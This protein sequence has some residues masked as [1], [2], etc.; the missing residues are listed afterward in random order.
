M[1]LFGDWHA[2][3]NYYRSAWQQLRDDDALRQDT[4]GAPVL[5]NPPPSISLP[6][7][8]VAPAPAAITVAYD[9]DLRGHVDNA[10]VPEDSP[11]ES[12]ATRALALTRKLTFRPRFEFGNPVSTPDLLREIP[13]AE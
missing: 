6:D 13:I 5:L 4:F 11:H 7:D 1:Q 10:R 12:A 8:A 3:L 9:V 2:A